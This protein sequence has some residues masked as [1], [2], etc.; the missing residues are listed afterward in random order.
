MNRNTQTICSAYSPWTTAC[1]QPNSRPPT[2]ISPF[3]RHLTSV[4]QTY[5]KDTNFYYLCFIICTRNR[6]SLHSS[7]RIYCPGSLLPPTEYLSYGSSTP[8]SFS[9]PKPMALNWGYKRPNDDLRPSPMIPL[10]KNDLTS[11]R[12][13]IINS[14]ND[15]LMTRHSSRSYL[16]R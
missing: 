10:P 13:P 1:C 16:S 3:Y 9:R 5:G 15:K 14:N 12:V 8:I 6:S 11:N 7:V 2:N 4:L